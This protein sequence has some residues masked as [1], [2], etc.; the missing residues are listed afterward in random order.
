MHTEDEKVAG[1]LQ[2]SLKLTS[3]AVLDTHTLIQLA[4]QIIIQLRG[5][6]KEDILELVEGSERIVEDVLLE[7]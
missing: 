4:I 5:Y 2:L 1:Y 3:I 7:G 6:F